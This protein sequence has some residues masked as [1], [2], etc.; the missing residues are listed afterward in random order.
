M[1][2]FQLY[3]DNL[4]LSNPIHSKKIYKFHLKFWLLST[5]NSK[6]KKDVKNIFNQ[7]SRIFYF[8][9]S[10]TTKKINKNFNNFLNHFHYFAI[11]CCEMAVAFVHFHSQQKSEMAPHFHHGNYCSLSFSFHHRPQCH[12]R[13]FCL[14]TWRRRRMSNRNH[15]W[16]KILLILMLVLER[17][18]GY[19][20]KFRKKL[21]LPIKST[22]CRA[23]SLIFLTSPFI[24]SSFLLSDPDEAAVDADGASVVGLAIVRF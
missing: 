9:F 1:L 15:H 18:W 2:K 8:K 17:K 24:S 13:V 5:W 3:S 20:M 16:V 4:I 14:S 7:K 21:N 19:L 10:I 11:E 23:N 12:L 22:I 6:N